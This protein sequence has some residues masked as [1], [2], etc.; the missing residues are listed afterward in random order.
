MMLNAPRHSD[1]HAHPAR[2]F[3]QLS[4]PP[5]DAAPR[6]PRSLPVMACVACVPPLW[7]RMMDRRAA[8]WR[9][10]GT[11]PGGAAVAGSAA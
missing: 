5:G 9:Q 7:R 10:G 4:L 3:P 11:G 8:A 6:L 2:P 1:H